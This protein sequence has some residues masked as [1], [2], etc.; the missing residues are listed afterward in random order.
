MSG[1]LQS[2]PQ[3]LEA[4]PNMEVQPIVSTFFTTLL[5]QYNQLISNIIYDFFFSPGCW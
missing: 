4:P 1:Y 3:H 5:Y 2:Y